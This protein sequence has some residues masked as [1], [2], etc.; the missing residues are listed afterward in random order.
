MP[1]HFDACMS[2][3]EARSARE[4]GPSHI[5]GDENGDHQHGKDEVKS[6]RGGE[7]FAEKDRVKNG[8]KRHA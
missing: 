5:S 4:T 7:F 2:Q 8:H 3:L 1:N 6:G